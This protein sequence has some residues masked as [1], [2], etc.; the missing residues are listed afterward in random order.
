MA[1]TAWVDYV[2]ARGPEIWLRTV[3]HLMLTGLS[4]VGAVLLGVPVG[5]LA[6]YR[7]RSRSVLLSLIGIL[8]TIPSLAMLALLLV[9]FGRIGAV[10]ALAALTLYALLPVV[11]N[12][13]VGLEGVDPTLGEAARGLGMT[14]RQELTMVRLP[15][16]LPVLAA[17]IRTAAVIGVGIATLS[18]FI[19][20]GGLGQFINR[21]LALSDTGLI[22]LGAV[23]AGILA[24]V[25][26]GSIAGLAWASDT[27][28]HHGAGGPGYA[29]LRSAAVA[30]PFLLLLVPAVDMLAF[31]R[32]RKA[33]IVRI[34]T[35]NFTEQILLGEIMAQLIEARTDL[36]V[37]RRFGL[38]GTIICHNALIAG[39]VDLYPEYTGTA[40]TAILGEDIES[41]ADPEDV[42]RVVRDAYVQRFDAQWLTPFG[43]DNTY[44]LMAK[45]SVVDSLGW[46]VVSDVEDRAPGLSVGFTAEFAERSDGYQGFAEHYGFTFGETRDLDPSIL[47]DAVADD[48][49][50]LAF[51][52]ATDGRIDSY[53]LEVLEDDQ[54]FFPPYQ[55]APVVRIAT[56]RA[57]PELRDALELLGNLLSDPTM[58][59]LN[60]E[61]EEG[62]RTVGDVAADFL[63][64]TSVLGTLPGPR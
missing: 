19:G 5:L 11:R 56:L 60:R 34:C 7:P 41:S 44:V 47:Y 3:E 48:Q 32:G 62:G 16:A 13:V 30:F 36:A 1:V 38:G 40:L 21:G 49:V 4:T 24:L 26:D 59:R 57:Y 25:V 63:A 45:R 42:F 8:Q 54:A 2:V 46:R 52:F 15:L 58:R 22:V 10:P 12:T 37:D 64:S 31:D 9:L 17:G 55:A 51:G 23:P 43:F 50:D 39:D 6:F 35:K 14:I 33:A 53:G 29:T 61:S 28:K 20:A 18:A 27:R